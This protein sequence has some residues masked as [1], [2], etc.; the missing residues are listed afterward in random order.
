MHQAENIKKI[1]ELELTRGIPP[2]TF[3]LSPRYVR[4]DSIAHAPP[5]N[6]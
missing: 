5:R 6:P 1:F 3:P 2:L 4:D